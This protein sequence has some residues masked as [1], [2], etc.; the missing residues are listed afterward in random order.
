MVSVMELGLIIFCIFVVLN[1]IFTGH[2]LI[3]SNISSAVMADKKSKY[4][5]KK[6]SKASSYSH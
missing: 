3:S 4:K 2:L 1:V 6:I 5:L